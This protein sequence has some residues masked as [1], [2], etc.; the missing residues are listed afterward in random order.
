MVV[1]RTKEY[2]CH[3][4]HAGSNLQKKVTNP[5]VK[6]YIVHVSE[7]NPQALGDGKVKHGFHLSTN[8]KFQPACEQPT[9]ALLED[10]KGE[11]VKSYSESLS[12]FDPEKYP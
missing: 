6:G 7:W 1:G 10:A 5:G 2:S 8:P 11:C 3:V 9:G 12:G 4:A